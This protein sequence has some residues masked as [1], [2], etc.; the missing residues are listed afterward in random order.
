[1]RAN[2]LNKYTSRAVLWFA[3]SKCPGRLFSDLLTPIS[4]AGLPTKP[5]L[6]KAD[7]PIKIQQAF[8]TLDLPK[9]IGEVV[10]VKRINWFPGHMKKATDTLREQVKKNHVI[11]EVRDARVK[12]IHTH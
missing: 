12:S 1:M 8:D 2:M 5:K 10:G 6:T 7:V 9:P 4:K 11:V 3:R